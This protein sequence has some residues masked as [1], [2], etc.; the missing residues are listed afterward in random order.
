MNDDALHDLATG[1]ALRALARQIHLLTGLAARDDAPDLLSAQLVPGQ[2]DLAAQ[3]RTVSIFA[4]RTVMPVI[5]REWSLAPAEAGIAGLQAQ[6]AD[7]ARQIAAVK[8]PA[9]DGASARRIMHKAG[10]AVLTQDAATYLVHFAVPNLWF[11]LSLAYAILR[12]AGVPVGKADFDGL[13]SY[14]DG[15]SFV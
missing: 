9:F 8:R 5:G 3:F 13:H 7:A 15:F 11:H 12:Q 6:A 1:S 2:F 14:P 10:D 4:L